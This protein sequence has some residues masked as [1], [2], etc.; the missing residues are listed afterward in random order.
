MRA[1]YFVATILALPA[2]VACSV[3]GSFERGSWMDHERIEFRGD[4][5]FTYCH[6]TDYDVATMISGTWQRTSR[7]HFV[8]RLP[9]QDGQP[10]VGGL[11]DLK[12]RVV[13]G[14]IRPIGDWGKFYRSGGGP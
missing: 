13:V 12:W 2:L 5:T 14:G 7:G 3:T 1:K 9:P 11:A 8:T 10:A 4:H 6:S